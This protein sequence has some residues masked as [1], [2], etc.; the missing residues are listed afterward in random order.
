MSTW[1]FPSIYTGTN[2]VCF[3]AV[4]GLL[5]VWEPPP[6]LPLPT[7]DATSTRAIAV[8]PKPEGAVEPGEGDGAGSWTEQRCRQLD[9]E[10]RDVCF[11]QLARGRAPTD[12]AGALDACDVLTDDGMKAECQ[13]DVAELHAPTD[14]DVAL[15]V[16]PT[17]AT[18]K[19][20]DQCVFGIALALS[21]PDPRYAFGLCDDAGQWYD[22]CR[23]DVVG[24]IAQ[25]DDAL[26]FELCAAEQGDLL[27]RKTCWHGMAK[28]IARI[29]VPRA[30]R[31]CGEV[32][33]GPDR[34]YRENCVHGLAWGAAETAGRDFLS[35]CG[36]LPEQRDSCRLG[37]AYFQ[38]RLD[39]AGALEICEEVERD[40]LKEKCQTFVRQMADR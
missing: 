5:Q 23:H 31:V 1:T 6:D 8:P 29:D 20:R 13:S 11:H 40:D 21:G 18:K 38:V 34:L 22:F 37:V 35:Q 14:R 16:C 32:P 19:W 9:G 28:Y 4:W 39:P 27:T 3:A 30:W 12:L 24:E 7:L 17:I 33:L 36:T 25:V 2:V 15:A 26:A 10:L